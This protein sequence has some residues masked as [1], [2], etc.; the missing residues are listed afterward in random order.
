MLHSVREKISAALFACLM[1]SGG[2]VCGGEDLANPDRIAT[3]VY[4]LNSPSFVERNRA[5]RMLHELGAEALPA[6]RKACDSADLEIRYRVKRLITAL[7]SDLIA[8][9][10]E[11]LS[12]GRPPIAPD[13]LP[14]WQAWLHRMGP[15]RESVEFYVEM[16]RAEPALMRAVD[17]P[18]EELRL[19]YES[20]CSTINLQRSQRSGLSAPKASI[21]ALLFVAAQPEFR[22]SPYAMPYLYAAMRQSEFAE[23]LREPDCPVAAAS[24]FADWIVRPE[25][26][27][28]V[29]RLNLAGE[30]ERPEV[31]DIAKQIVDSGA[32][33]PQVQQAILYIAEHGGIDVLAD[34]EQFL[35]DETQLGGRRN[36]SGEGLT[37]RVQDVA[38]IA[39]LLLTDQDPEA[40]GFRDLRA[41]HRTLPYHPNTIGFRSDEAREAA[42]TAWRR[43]SGK[44]LREVQPVPEY[45]VEG[46]LL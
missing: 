7:E 26:G 20:R 38:L 3:L 6:L 14:G 46:V 1:A 16:V 34:I 5:E 23:L 22:P 41:N 31:F 27:N 42:L 15:D 13:L 12:D 2:I 37:A 35:D 32:A 19:H 39:L 33:G 30:F 44:N 9:S 25:T 11:C 4:R 28:A 8:E 17:G 24:L 18:H 45:A 21:G 40:Y 43:W 10:L 36:R 29:Q